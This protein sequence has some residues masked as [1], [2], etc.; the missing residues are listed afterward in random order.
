MKCFFF[1]L[2]KISNFLLINRCKYLKLRYIEV[3]TELLIQKFH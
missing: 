3:S 2:F 1:F